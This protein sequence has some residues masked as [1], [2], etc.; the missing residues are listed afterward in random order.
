MHEL[1]ESACREGAEMGD[2]EMDLVRKDASDRR[3]VI[4]VQ[5]IGHD[6]ANWRPGCCSASTT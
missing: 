1:L 5:Y 3:L 6:D 4:N 2:Q